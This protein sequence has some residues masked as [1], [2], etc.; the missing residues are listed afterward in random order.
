MINTAQLDMKWFLFLTRR[1]NVR[2]RLFCFTYAGGNP[3]IFRN[4]GKFLPDYVEVIAL[5]LPG[6]YSRIKEENFTSWSSLLAALEIAIMP[7]LHEPFAFFGHSF[8]GRIIYE[9]TRVL[10]AKNKSIPEWLFIAGC[11]CPHIPGSIP[12][13]YN[14]PT[15]EFYEN[16]NKMNGTPTEILNT[17]GLMKII[18]PALRADMQL[19]ELWSGCTEN[20]VQTPIVAMSGI[21]DNIDRPDTMCEWDK[22]TLGEYAFYKLDGDHFSL[23]SKELDL[24]NII[25]FYIQKRFSP[26][27]AESTI[28]A[29]FEVQ[30]AKNP[31]HIALIYKDVSLTYAELNARA[32]QLA[33][34]LIAQGVQ[35]GDLVGLCVERSFDM[36]IS[37]LAIL[38]TGAA[39]LPLD[40]EYPQ[41]RLQ[42]ILNDSCVRIILTKTEF[43]SVLQFS[44]QLIDLQEEAQKVASQ[45]N[46][47]PK[48]I[49]HGGSLAYVN[50]TSGSTGTPK[51]VEVLHKGVMRL[52][53]N[54]NYATLNSS[55]TFLQLA[56]VSFDATTF[57]LWGALLHGAK[58]V[59]YEDKLPTLQKLKATIK[60][61]NISVLF[62]TTALFNVIIDEDHGIFSE[63]RESL[64]EV[65]RS[66]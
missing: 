60:K 7:F 23:C 9:L 55:Q 11:R 15:E 45:A 53:F 1:Q 35:K 44:S 47:N 5:V 38:K 27:P 62:I 36:V 3:N 66:P 17:K 20:K 50:Y 13:M 37:L 25:D 14:L 42:Y 19:S 8:G 16:L 21:H 10:Q 24:L 49:G 54:T 61:Q 59:L 31:T 22:Y 41:E 30:V 65:R 39:Y 58:C 46:T 18:E 12:Y 6:R 2:I 26:Y 28:Q 29:M 56:S 4:W 64:L 51:G 43:K 40:A 34:Y 63:I 57:E 32:N 33:H 52:I 48:L